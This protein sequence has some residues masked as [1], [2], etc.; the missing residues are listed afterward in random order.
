MTAIQTV[1]WNSTAVIKTRLKGL[2]FPK[3][4]R[5]LIAKKCK[6]RRKWHQSRNPHNKDIQNRVSQQ[7]SKEIRTMKQSLINKFLTE[8]TPDSSTEYS[9]WKATKYL[10]SSI[11]QVPPIKKADER[12]AYNNLEKA[13]TVAQHLEKRFHLNPGLDTLAVLNSNVYLDKIP[14]VT[15]REVAKEIRTNLNP[16]KAPGFDL[17]AGEIVKNFKR[18]AL[19]KLT[20]LINACIRLNY[21]PDAWKTAEV[22]MI[23]KPGKNLSERESYQPISLLPVMSKLILKR[24]K[25]IIAEKHLVPMHQ[26]GFRKKSLYSKPGAVY[27]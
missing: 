12:W 11:A 4:I 13:I 8:L 7:L 27:R 16:K 6:L 18:K 22:I 15:P 24:L 25:P 5:N 23:V 3:E 9:L 26:F 20:T 19:V 10:K 17:T 1:A 21:I 14:L 2:N